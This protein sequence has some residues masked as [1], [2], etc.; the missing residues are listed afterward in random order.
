MDWISFLAA[1]NKSGHGATADFEA[2]YALRAP[3]VA[4]HGDTSSDELF[5]DPWTASNPS[6][7][8]A[9]SLRTAT[10]LAVLSSGRS[11]HLAVEQSPV[12][13]QREG[14]SSKEMTIVCGEAQSS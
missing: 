14:Q 11:M 10:V 8:F 4:R 3:A 9:Q 6:G 5:E 7:R 1:E 2:C 13:E 12:N